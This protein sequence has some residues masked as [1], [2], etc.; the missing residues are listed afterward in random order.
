[1]VML[2][3]SGGN[4]DLWRF[5]KFSTALIPPSWSTFVYREVMSAD[6]SMVLGWSLGRFWIRLR[7]CLVSF[8]WEFKFAVRGDRI[9]AMKSEILSVGESHPEMMGRGGIPGLCVLGRK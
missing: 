6:T 5:R 4:S 8:T 1:M 2:G 3:V 7:K 9:L